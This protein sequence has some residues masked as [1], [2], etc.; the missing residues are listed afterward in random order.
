MEPT[1][2]ELR[3][4]KDLVQRFT[5]LI[6]SFNMN[7]SVQPVG[8]YVTNLYLPTSDIDMVI[9]FDGYSRHL[10]MLIRKIRDSGFASQVED[11]LRASVPLIRITDKIT[12]IQID[13]TAADTHAIKA[14]EAVQ[15]WLEPSSPV[16][17]L[18]FVVKMF[19]SVRRC[20][21][22]YTGGLN[23]Y[24][25][26]WMVVAWVKLEMGPKKKPVAISDHDSL[27]AALKELFVSTENVATSSSSSV[28]VDL[29]ELLIK[30]LKF[31]GEE[32]NYET[33]A[34][35]ITPTPAYHTKAYGYSR[36]PITQRYLLSIY[37]PA[38]RFVD[39]GSKAYGIKHIQASFKNAYQSLT[40]LEARR[41]S[42]RWVGEAGILG[43]VL[44]G[45]YTKFVEKRRLAVARVPSI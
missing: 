27:V 20:G 21:T 4:R 12:G 35:R 24:A 33:E 45:D 15:K 10:S 19:L 44:G 7:A 2:Q 42:G 30:F 43:S 14:T 25:L 29:G 23:S 17:P 34:I 22:T 37:D 40:D 1:P 13:L 32:F 41:K 3:M 18:L 16:K 38:D 39:M 36:Y 11:V 31:Y 8:S 9:T 5:K 6:T 26:F 28:G